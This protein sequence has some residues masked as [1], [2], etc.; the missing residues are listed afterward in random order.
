MLEAES[1]KEF[2]AAVTPADRAEDLKELVDGLL[3]Q[4]PSEHP[5]A[6]CLSAAVASL[7]AAQREFRKAGA[8]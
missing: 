7:A 5:A 1:G 8:A 3:E 6:R 4:V 2:S